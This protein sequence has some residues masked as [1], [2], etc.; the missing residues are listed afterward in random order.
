MMATP[1]QKKSMVSVSKKFLKKSAFKGASE[2][3][4]NNQSSVN[5]KQIYKVIV[6]ATPTKALAE[7]PD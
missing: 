6:K 3:H 4:D 2:V 5:K 1:V 7:S